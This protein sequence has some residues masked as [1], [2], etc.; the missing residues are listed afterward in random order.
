LPETEEVSDPL[1]SWRDTATRQAIED[2]V[3]RAARGVPHDW[4]KVFA[5]QPT[6]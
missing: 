3:E 5:E 6:S 2:F 4:D 1:A